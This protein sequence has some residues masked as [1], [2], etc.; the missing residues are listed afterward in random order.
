LEWDRSSNK[1]LIPN[2]S[3][4]FRSDKETDGDGHLTKVTVRDADGKVLYIQDGKGFHV[5]T[6]DGV[7]TQTSDGKVSFKSNKPVAQQTA[8]H[9]V[10]ITGR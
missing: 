7:L 10:E 2:E 6:A 1:I 9:S 5:P 4:N 8:L 3:Q